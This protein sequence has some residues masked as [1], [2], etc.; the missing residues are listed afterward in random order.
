MNE[1]RKKVVAYLRISS[2]KQIDNESPDTQRESI[3]KYADSQGFEII[4]WFFDE[5]KSGKNADREELN[6]LIDF[7]LKYRGKIEHVLVYK[8]NRMSRDIDSYITQVKVILK[9]R[10]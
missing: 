6:N 8:M 5:A 3:Q 4:E 1:A 9:A 10:G 2:V 7:A